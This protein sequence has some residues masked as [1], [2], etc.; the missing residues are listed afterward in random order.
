MRQLRSLLLTA[1]TQSE[2]ISAPD[3]SRKIIHVDMDA[4]Y[5]TVEQR[6]DARLRSIPIAVNDHRGWGVVA[7]A[8]YEARHHGVRAGM[9]LAEA[10]R[11]LPGLTIV[12]ARMDVYREASAQAHAIFADFT[13]IIEPIMLDE[14]YLDVT[15]TTLPSATAVAVEIRQRIRAELGLVA[16]AGVS[17]NKFLAKLGSD[18]IKPDGLLVIRPKDGQTFVEDLAIERFHGVGKA[19][20]EK[21]ARLGIRT[22]RDLRN[23]PL[24]NLIATFGKK[25]KYFHEIGHGDDSGPVIV[26]RPRKSYSVERSFRKPMQSLEEVQRG[27]HSIVDDVW[28]KSMDYD[29]RGRHISL[30]LRFSDFTMAAKGRTLEAPFRTREELCVACI[31]LLE[32]LGPLPLDVRLI[33]VSIGLLV[34]R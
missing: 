2:T 24:E 15:A 6:D 17:Y 19:T 12:P 10:R 27:L 30:K 23:H 14:A 9:T 13:A 5:A 32:S 18:S 4:F 34:Q 31:C 3:R 22:G 7:A 26:D 20:A 16:S 33:G 29:A 21:M 25:G 1:P 8:S 28:A 11:T